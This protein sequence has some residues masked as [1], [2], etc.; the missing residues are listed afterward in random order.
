MHRVGLVLIL[1]V[2]SFTSTAQF[3]THG[4]VIGAVTD[5]SARMY[6][7]TTIPNAQLTLELVAD[8]PFSIPFKVSA[9][10]VPRNDSSVVLGIEQ[11]SSNTEYH[12]RIFVNQK[13][14]TIAGSFRTFPAVGE[15]GEFTFVTGSCQETENMKV[16]DVMP[17]HNPYFLMHTGDYTYPDYQIAPDYSSTWDGMALSYRKRYDEK[18][19]K[20]ML[21]SV[22]IDYVYDDNDYVGGSG[23]RFCKNDWK[24]HKENGRVVNEMFAP[25]FPPFWR[26]N[27]IKGYDEFFPHYPLVDTSE[28]IYHSFKFGNAEFFVI[29]RNSAKDRPNKDGFV[30]DEKKKKWR[31]DPPEGYA[32]FGKKQMDWLKKSLKESDADWKFIVSG[33]PL[34]GACEKLIHAGV[35]IQNMSMKGFYGFHMAWGFSQYWAGFPEERNDFMQFLED[36]DI[37]DVIVISGDTHHNVM[38]DGS[39]AGLPEL[40]ASGLSVTGTELAYYLKLIGTFTFQYRMK[41]IWNQGGNGLGTKN[42]KNAFGKVSIVNDDYVELS[43]IDEDNAVISSFQVPHS[44]K[45]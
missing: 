23:G 11:L 41:K 29:D 40:N 5:S 43:I 19:M 7:R 25:E 27:T 15:K 42:L 36:N 1:V 22:P 17:L 34:N 3:I 18:E 44:S 20:Y 38:D 4:P 21:R 31:W 2:I 16:F 35:K 14:D 37:N 6:L 9:S 10:P 39:N 24:A 33:V 30:Y 8:D 32:L 45:K 13:P 12:Y 28:G 26:R